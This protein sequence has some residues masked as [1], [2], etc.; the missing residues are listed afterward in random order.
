MGIH[1]GSGEEGR[2]DALF[3]GHH[4]ERGGFQDEDVALSNL[5]GF[6]APSKAM[7]SFTGIRET[8]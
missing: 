2:E 5:D 1:T 8:W 4:Q 3:G 7:P 6:G